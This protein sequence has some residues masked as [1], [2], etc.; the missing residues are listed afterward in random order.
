MHLP[1]DSNED[2]SLLDRSD[3][4]HLS[5]IEIL[6]SRRTQAVQT[7]KQVNDTY[8][9]IL[10]S[11]IE[12]HEKIDRHLQY[13]EKEANLLNIDL[14]S[15]VVDKEEGDVPVHCSIQQADDLALGFS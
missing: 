13:K 3:S 4:I 11:E 15:T 8:K 2:S 7:I 1:S 12:L 10:D 14:S 5:D 9:K 6:E